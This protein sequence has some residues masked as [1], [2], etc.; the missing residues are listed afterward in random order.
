MFTETRVGRSGAQRLSGAVAGE[1]LRATPAY[2]GIAA[3]IALIAHP[4]PESEKR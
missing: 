4:N 1:A 2:A 3:G